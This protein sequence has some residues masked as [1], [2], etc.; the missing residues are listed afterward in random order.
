LIRDSGVS[1]LEVSGAGL[2]EAFLTLTSATANRPSY[3]NAEAIAG[4]VR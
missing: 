2:E 3:E 1:G 4:G